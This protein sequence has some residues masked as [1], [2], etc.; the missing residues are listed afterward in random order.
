MRRLF[1]PSAQPEAMDRRIRSPY[2]TAEM[3]FCTPQFLYF[4]AIVLAVY[5]VIPWR[6]GRTYWLLAA[7]FYFYAT[8][9]E[10]LALVV[11]ASST[12]DYFIARGMDH[13]RQQRIRKLLLALSIGGNLSLL[14]YF[15]YCNFFIDSLRQ[16]LVSGGIQTSGP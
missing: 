16:M 14:A 15:K 11:A 1:L 8:W 12:A 4:A 10:Y 13:F 9:N 2:G 5:W 3:L 7:S 6:A